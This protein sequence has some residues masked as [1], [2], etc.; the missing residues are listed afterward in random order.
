MLLDKFFFWL[1]KYFF[2]FFAGFEGNFKKDSDM[3]PNSETGY[4]GVPYNYDSI[5]HYGKQY[6][7]K[8]QQNTIDVKV[9]KFLY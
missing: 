6:F 7:S 1:Y 4:F 2:D 8:N 3:Y 9:G 5:M